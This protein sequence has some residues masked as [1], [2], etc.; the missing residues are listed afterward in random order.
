M[1]KVMAGAEMI[2]VPSRKCTIMSLQYASAQASC[3]VGLSRN[4][5]EDSD[6]A[7][8]DDQ[9]ASSYL[10]WPAQGLG[11]GGSALKHEENGADDLSR[12]H[13]S[14][15]QVGSARKHDAGAAGWYA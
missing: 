5:V 14:L 15:V 4:H 2:E 13:S 8:V 3:Q 11:G 12:Y 1:Q 6:I 7:G 9:E 10:T